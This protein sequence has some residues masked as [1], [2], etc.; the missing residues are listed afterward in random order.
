LTSLTSCEL[1]LACDQW[2]GLSRSDLINTGQRYAV[3]RGFLFFPGLVRK[4]RILKSNQCIISLCFYS[5]LAPTLRKAQVSRVNAIYISS[6]SSFPFQNFSSYL[7]HKI[8]SSSIHPIESLFP[9]I[10]YIIRIVRIKQT[11][12][13]RK[14]LSESL[15]FNFTVKITQTLYLYVQL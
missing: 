11:L 5:L 13:Y 1:I 9:L 14:D 2:L 8:P 15:K 12:G 7:C 6:T 3:L 4:N 10:L